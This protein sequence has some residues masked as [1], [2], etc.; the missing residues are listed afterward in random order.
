VAVA[1]AAVA[2]PS[3]PLTPERAEAAAIANPI[4]H[5]VFIV[6]ENRSFDHYFGRFPGV[7]GTRRFRCYRKANPSVVDVAP[8]PVAPDP[9]PQDVSHAY[10][11]FNTAYHGGAMDGFCHEN[12]AIVESTGE[13]IADT[14][15]RE[16]G[17]PNYWAYARTY[18]LADRMFASWKGASF[19]NNVFAVAAQTGRYSTEY[20]RRAIY[21]NPSDPA[22]G[23]TTTWGCDNSAGTLVKMMAL[24]GSLS[25][26][27]PCFGFDTI[28]KLLERNGHSW[29]FYGISDEAH[30]VHSG[31]AAMREIRCLPGEAEP[32][33]DPNPYWNRHVDPGSAFLDDAAEG[34]LPD[35][36][37][38]LPKQNEHPPKMACAGEN[39]V[40]E[41]VNTVMQGPDWRSTAV[42]IWWDEWG[43]FYDHVRPPT[44]IGQHGG[45]SPLNR[46]ISYGFRVPLLVISP[47][48]KTG[49]SPAGG[50]APEGGGYVSSRFYSHA[51]FAR[52]VEWVYGLPDMN[53]ADDLS[54]Y[55]ANEP[56]P[57]DL[58]DFF[59]LRD[60]RPQH[61]R[62]VLTMR[63]CGTLTRE[64]REYIETWNPD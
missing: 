9:M 35:V 46:R 22:P 37:W 25:S 43:G 30:W 23:P 16:R 58:S 7:N 19:G 1:A 39:A 59:D 57:G 31:I 15:F 5:I 44:G 62:L 8:L 33:T 47:W 10:S 4:E 18:G 42:V 21:G 3:G 20:Q 26:V 38:Y 36:S 34:T 49:D 13:D 55:V 54:T 17:I 60:D 11:T 41:A 28:P 6:K 56:K 40:V 24:D 14:Q 63:R 29:R 52:F 48:V 32:C 45:V 12:N 51:S 50:R 27:F 53:A 2:V 61:G 64:M